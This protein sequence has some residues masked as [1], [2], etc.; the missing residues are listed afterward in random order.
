MHEK[1]SQLE[2]GELESTLLT[3]AIACYMGIDLSPE[4][5][6]AELRRGAAVVMFGPPQ[7][8]CSTRARMLAERYTAACGHCHQ[9]EHC[10]R[11][12]AG[13]AEGKEGVH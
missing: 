10:V 4:A 11:A 2:V 7:S 1:V 3:A 6:R 5:K 8:G 9:G 13:W 12:D